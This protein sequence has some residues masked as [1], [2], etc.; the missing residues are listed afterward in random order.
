MFS[1]IEVLVHLGLGGYTNG[2]RGASIGSGD[3]EDIERK[4]AGQIFLNVCWLVEMRSEIE[5]NVRPRSV[6]REGDMGADCWGRFDCKKMAT[7]ET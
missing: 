5:T 4:T 3:G 7:K 2:R 6:V 1:D